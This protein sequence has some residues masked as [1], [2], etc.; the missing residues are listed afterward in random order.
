MLKRALEMQPDNTRVKRAL[1][2]N[3]MYSEN[4][5]ESLKLFTEVAA[6]EPARPAGAPAHLRDLPPE[7]RFRQGAGG[8]RKSQAARPRQ[9]GNPV[10]RSE[11]AGCRGQD[12]RG[13]RPDEEHPQRHGE[14]DLLRRRARQPRHA[15]RTAGDPAIAAPT[16]TM[17]PSRPSARLPPSTRITAPAPWSRWWIPTVP[18]TTTPRPQAEADAAL[19]KFPNDRMVKMVHASLLADT[20]QG[21]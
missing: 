18:R 19:K 8:A 12:R 21:G 10:R 13:H 15:A 3:L 14:E 17:R 11:P 9:P 6:E 7:A 1:A 2:Q 4:Y 16:S 5:D 20:G